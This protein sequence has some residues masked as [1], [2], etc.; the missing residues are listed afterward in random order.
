MLDEGI[1]SGDAAFMQKANRRMQELIEKA[2]ILVLASHSAELVRQFCTRA[3]LMEQGRI[4]K[5]GDV[6]DVLASYEKRFDP[7]EDLLAG[8]REF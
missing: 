4:I 7:A 3:V 2:G 6:K 1:A 5:E 8:K